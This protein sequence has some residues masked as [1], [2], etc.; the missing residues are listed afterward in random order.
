MS[1]RARNFICTYYG[2]ISQFK[3]YLTKDNDL[4]YC[5]YQLEKCPSTARLHVQGYLEYGKPMRVGRI[6]RLLPGVH[7]EMREGTRH[8]AITYCSKEETRVEGPF[9]HGERGVIQQGK[10]KDLDEIR[11][12]ILNGRSDL[13]IAEMNFSAFCR[14]HK[15]FK[16]F[17]S[18]VSQDRHFK[19]YVSVFWGRPGAGKT[20]RVYELEDRNNVFDVP[21]PNGGNVWF[22]GYEPTRHSAILLDDFYGWIPLHFM[23]KL[24]DRYPM[25]VPVKGSYV[26]FNS[27]KIYITSNTAWDTWYNFNQFDPHLK[28]A[29]KRRL[30]NIHHYE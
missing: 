7:L 20:R 8:Q 24:M 28:E 18:M 4:K 1:G 3:E 17:R 26:N 14:Y 25:Q 9:E 29:F 21:R 22:D 10:R 13:E 16:M 15:S 11:E 12:A 27:K 23:L 5:I 6:K 19:T 30:D 2:D